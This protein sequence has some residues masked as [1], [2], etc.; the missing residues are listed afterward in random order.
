MPTARRH[1]HAFERTLP[2]QKRGIPSIFSRILRAVLEK[3]VRVGHQ[4]RQG[5]A[6]HMRLEM[7]VPCPATRRDDRRGD[8]FA[9]RTNCERD[10]PTK[11]RRRPTAARGTAEHDDRVDLLEP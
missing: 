11:R 7:T 10:A 1:H 2:Q 3:N 5:V 6:Y 9:M 8:T 4:L